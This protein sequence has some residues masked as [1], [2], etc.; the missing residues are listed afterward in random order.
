MNST[1]V[2]DADAAFKSNA[3]NVAA[4]VRAAQRRFKND[5]AAAQAKM[6]VRRRLMSRIPK[7]PSPQKNRMIS[8]KGCTTAQTPGALTPPLI[9]EEKSD[10]R[11]CE[12]KNPESP[13]LGRR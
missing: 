10:A 2:N 5:V 7:T 1:V 3:P 12:D 6:N 11:A 8:A 4:Q 9:D 13:E